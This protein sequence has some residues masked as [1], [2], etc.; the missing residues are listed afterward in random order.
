MKRSLLFLVVAAACSNADNNADTTAMSAPVQPQEIT[1]LAK[2]FAFVAPDTVNPGLTRIN[3]VNEGPNLHHAFFVRLDGGKTLDDLNE[4]FRNLKPSDPFPS[5]AVG[6]G[7]PN[8]PSFGDSST[9]VQELQPGTYAVICMVDI[10]DK[11]PHIAKGMT[12]SLIVREA[13]V[14]AAAEPVPTLT[15]SLQDYTFAMSQQLTAGHNVIKVENM[16]DQPHEL[17]IM[18]LNEGKT[19]DDLGQ[20]A[21]TMTGPIPAEAVGG[22]APFVKGQ[23]IYVPVDLI[24]G[25][26]VLLCLVPDSKDGKPHS[27]H[28]MVMPITVS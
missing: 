14:S 28:G 1:I 20:W 16:A 7:G 18:K 12:T 2:D 23:T 3:L 10:P 13:P 21:A 4:A 6:I 17:I 8:P 11:I 26:Y 19:M 24:P 25:N 27:E 22:I 9:V 15:M 5:W